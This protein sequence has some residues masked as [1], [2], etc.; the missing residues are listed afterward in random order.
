MLGGFGVAYYQVPWAIKHGALQT[1]G[2]EAAYVI[3]FAEHASCLILNCRSI[4][5][6]LFVLIV[7]PLQL[8]GRTLRVRDSYSLTL[9]LLFCSY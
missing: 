3:F 1:L 7:L 9:T 4:V 2:C 6:G 8:T 5:A